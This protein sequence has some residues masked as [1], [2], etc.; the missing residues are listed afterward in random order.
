MDSGESYKMKIFYKKNI[1]ILFVAFFSVLNMEAQVKIGDNHNTI[2]S[3]SLLELEST[4]KGIVFPRVYLD[5]DLSVWALNGND[6]MDGMVVFNTNTTNDVGLYCWYNNQWNHFSSG[7]NGEELDSLSF[8]VETRYLYD[9][10]DRVQIPSGRVR[11]VDSTGILETLLANDYTTEGDIYYVSGDGVY[12]RNNNAS[13]TTVDDGYI[14]IS[15]AP[16]AGHI[17]YAN[18]SSIQS[19]YDTSQF[20]LGIADTFYQEPDDAKVLSVD[21]PSSAG[22]YYVFAVP[23]DWTSPRIFLKVKNSADGGFY[24]LNNCWSV[25][26]DLEFEGV[27][28]QVWA[29]DVPMRESVMDIIGSKAQFMI[30]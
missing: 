25:T 2:N 20:K 4:N 22:N 23:S 15:T 27:R 26:R 16:K 11:V 21:T 19:V 8:N 12:V 5:D 29:L 28:Y 14:Y 13:A 7:G 1:Y 10:G 6:A 3:G 30:E 18:F 24:I 17:L 9:D